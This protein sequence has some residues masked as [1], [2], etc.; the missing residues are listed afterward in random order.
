MKPR[1]L[2]FCVL[3]LAFSTLFGLAMDL[4]DRVVTCVIGFTAWL[5]VVLA[6]V[7]LFK[8]FRQDRPAQLSQTGGTR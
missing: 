4:P 5:A 6:L 3:V 7:I 1:T 8:P 2:A